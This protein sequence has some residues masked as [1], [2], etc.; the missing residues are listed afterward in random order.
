MALND[1]VPIERMSRRPLHR[2]AG[3]ATVAFVMA[4]MSSCGQPEPVRIGFLG[5]LMS[6]LGVGGRNGAQLAVDELDARQPG[7]YELVVQDDRNDPVAARAAIATC[8]SRGAAFVVGPMTSAMAVLAVPE[9]NRL[10]MVLIS[11]TATTGELSARDDFFFRTAA[12]APA[13][14]RQLARLLHDRG[15]RS[16]SVLMDVANSQLLI[17]LWPCHRHRVPE[18][19]GNGGLRN[20]L[21]IRELT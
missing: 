13:G 5:D 12:D 21:P 14:A 2:T 17:E 19:A 8:Q 15:A 10:G 20:R 9:A 18:V 16:M 1:Q 4:V 7:R 11:P 6:D 3:A